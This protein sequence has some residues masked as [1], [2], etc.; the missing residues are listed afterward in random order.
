MAHV[1]DR[2]DRSPLHMAAHANDA[3]RVAG[4]IAEGAEIDLQDKDGLT[5]LHLAAQEYG[6]DAARR[7]L[8]SGAAVDAV[9][10]HGNSPLFVATFNSRGRGGLIELLQEYGADPDLV[11]HHGQTPRGLAKLVGNYDVERFF[12]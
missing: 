9:N 4:L 1:V 7:L 3:D 5:P 2:D 8:A 12:N 6:V 11:N 10:D